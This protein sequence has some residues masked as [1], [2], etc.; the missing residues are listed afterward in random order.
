MTNSTLADHAAERPEATVLFTMTDLLRFKAVAQDARFPLTEMFFDP[1]AGELR[2]LAL[3]VGGWFDRHEVIVAAQL[4]GVPDVAH[5]EWPVA[6][7]KEAI[8]QA[9]QWS[10]P[11]AA[12]I[13]PIGTM[14]PIMLGPHGGGFA[15]ALRRADDGA[16]VEP[17]LPGNLRVEGLARLNEWV[18]LPVLGRDGEVGVL[19]DLVLE[20]DSHRLSHL[21]IDTGGFFAAHQ[22]VV[23]YDLMEGLAADGHHVAMN[24]T[25][26]LLRE[27]PPLDHF[28][29]I[30]RSW[31]DALRAYYQVS[32]GL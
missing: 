4:M 21:V 13:V 27:A 2:H 7:T 28:D 24:V 3:D 5:R 8:S 25:A 11:M 10:D 18:G 15:G 26:E 16:P 9:P 12:M 17:Q 1:A 23:P 32:A 19:A 29:R 20:P 22:M 31:L 30:S 14:P 6:I